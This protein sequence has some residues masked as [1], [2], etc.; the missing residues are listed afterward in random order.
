[1]ASESVVCSACAELVPGAH[2]D[3]VLLSCLESS[4]NDKVCVRIGHY[5]LAQ[6]L[7]PISCTAQVKVQKGGRSACGENGAA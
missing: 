4:E 5:A 3:A 6:I 7:P 1:M 2:Q